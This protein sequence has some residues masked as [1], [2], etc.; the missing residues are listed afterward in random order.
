MDVPSAGLSK[1]VSG[2]HEDVAEECELFHR[3]PGRWQTKAGGGES[4]PERSG[5]VVG[6]GEAGMGERGVRQRGA[7]TMVGAGD[8]WRATA[9]AATV[10]G[11]VE[12]GSGGAGGG[13]GVRASLG[14]R[15][16]A[17]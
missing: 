10:G 3:V 17:G 13:L 9:V 12:G 8:L 14:P 4:R 2:Q 11:G 15:A 16:A 7:A 6:Q 1:G 5:G